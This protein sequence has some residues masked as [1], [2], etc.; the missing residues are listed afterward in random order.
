M[1]ALDVRGDAHIVAARAASWRKLYQCVARRRR[2]SCL[3]AVKHRTR[4]A[5]LGDGTA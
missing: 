5:F 3:I 1:G 4:T 2:G